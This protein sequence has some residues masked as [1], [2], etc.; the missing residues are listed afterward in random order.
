MSKAQLKSLEKALESGGLKVGGT[1]AE[2]VEKAISLQ[3]VLEESGASKEKISELLKKVQK[4][5]E[6][7]N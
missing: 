2:T 6:N 4:G 3:K 5:E 7:F 1:N